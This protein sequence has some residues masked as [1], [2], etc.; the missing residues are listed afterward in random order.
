M[1]PPPRVPT[2][3]SSVHPLL[4]CPMPKVGF[5]FA[6]VLIHVLK[7]VLNVNPHARMTSRASGSFGPVAHKNSTLVLEARAPTGSA[8][9]SSTLIVGYR[10]ETAPSPYPLESYRHGQ[11]A[12][13]TSYVG[14]DG[15]ASGG[16][17]AEWDY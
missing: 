9:R 15:N 7:T 6:Y 4:Q 16:V 14:V 1:Y 17:A 10:W 8:F 3:K 13:M 2:N 12:N 5:P 11:S